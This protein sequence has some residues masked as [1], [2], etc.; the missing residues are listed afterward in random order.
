MLLRLQHGPQSAIELGLALL[1]DK[2]QRSQLR[3]V[4]RLRDMRR[5]G[6]RYLGP[7]SLPEQELLVL[8]RR[9]R[10]ADQLDRLCQLVRG[11]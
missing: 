1:V 6:S 5:L 10:F 9:R 8:Q 2:D 3:V 7:D 4:D 11:R